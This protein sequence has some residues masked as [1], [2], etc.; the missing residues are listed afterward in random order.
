VIRFTLSR[1]WPQAALA[2]G[3][4]VVI[5]VALMVSG[6][7]LYQLWDTTLAPCLAAHPAIARYGAG[8]SDACTAD[9]L[10]LRANYAPYGWVHDAAGIAVLVVPAL[11]GP[12]LAVA[13]AAS[14]AAAGLASWLVTWWAG[15]LDQ[16]PN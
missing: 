3:L 5:A 15:P 11:I 12:F 1:F 8:Y 9:F 2:A 14:I 16:A 4:L 7:H 10:T 13:G 6:L